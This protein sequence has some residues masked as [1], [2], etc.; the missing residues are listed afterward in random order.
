M[1]YYVLP[2]VS[3]AKV[4]LTGNAVLNQSLH[5][6][7]GELRDCKTTTNFKKMVDVLNVFPLKSGPVRAF[8]DVDF[9]N[10][11]KTAQGE[12][13]VNEV[14]S[15]EATVAAYTL[16]AETANKTQAENGTAYYFIDQKNQFG[17]DTA[18]ALYTVCGAYES[19]KLYYQAN[20]NEFVVYAKNYLNF[21]PS[22]TT[23]ESIPLLF[24]TRLCEA[25]VVLEQHT[26]KRVSLQPTLLQDL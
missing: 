15:E 9:V 23:L 3:F 2:R 14:P 20:S 19:V 18:A 22:N 5:E 26:L 16:S 21:G 1:N 7:V 13:N 8:G 25:F 4:K 12:E 10:A 6:Y 24:K 17:A 11:M